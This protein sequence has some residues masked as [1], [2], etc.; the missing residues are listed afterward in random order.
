[1]CPVNQQD[2]SRCIFSC[3][4]GPRASNAQERE[5]I[6]PP[7]SEG[8]GGEVGEPRNLGVG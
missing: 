6:A 1:M 3:H 2:T 5:K 4:S 8:V 7:S